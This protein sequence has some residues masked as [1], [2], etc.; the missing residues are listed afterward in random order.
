MIAKLF[1]YTCRACGSQNIVK[2]GHNAS[3]SQQYWCKDCGK[4]G[5]LEPRRGYTEEQKEQILAAYNE[6]SSMRGIKRTFGVSRPTL[7]SWIKKDEANPKLEDTLLPAEPED[8]LEAHEMWSFVYQRWNKRWVW[9]VMCRRTRQIVAFVIGD[10]SEATCRKLWEQIPHAYKRCHSYSD[11]WE[12]YQLGFPTETHQC[13]RKGSGQ[14]NH[15]ERWYNTFRQSSAR[16]ARK[17]LSFSKSD[18]L[19]KIVTRLFIIRHKLSLVS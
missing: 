3:G 11:F 4:R 18:S 8:I 16:F 1:I 10:H 7:A 17:T 9:T 19:H 15:M 13:V 5:V 2:N 12:A 6:R 14:T